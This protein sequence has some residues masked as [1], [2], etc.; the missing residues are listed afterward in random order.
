MAQ[1]SST[2]IAVINM[3][4]IKTFFRDMAFSKPNVINKI[5]YTIFL[6]RRLICI[7]QNQHPA[8]IRIEIRIITVIPRYFQLQRIAIDIKSGT[9]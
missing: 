7:K 4:T 3:D 6:F 8:D 5:I 2:P 9:Q 1:A